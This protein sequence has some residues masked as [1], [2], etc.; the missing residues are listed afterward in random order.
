M[1]VLVFSHYFELAKELISAGSGV[2]EV[3]LLL[4]SDQADREGEVKGVKRVIICDV[5]SEDQQGLLSVIASLAEDYDLLILSSDKRGRE[6]IGQVAQKLERAVATEVS[7]L[8]LSDGKL[9]VERMTY[10]GKAI[11]VEELTLPAVI[12]VQKGKFKPLDTDSTHETL[13]CKS[14]TARSYEVLERRP[15][16]KLGIPL[17]KADV[18]VAAGRGFKRKEDLKLAYELA[19]L[20]NGVVGSTRPLAADLK[21]MPEESWIGI[22]GVRIAPKLLFVVGA[23]GQQQFS[24][25]IIDSKVI[26][27]V[28][29]DPSAPIFE[30]SDYCIVRDL[31]EFLPALIKKLRG[32]R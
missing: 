7:S 6:L 13:H 28:N 17:D 29:N 18:V 12:S 5:S 10:G 30:N 11:S 31:Y 3:S 1:K 15:K 25:G 2:G 23:S 9:I 20:F 27:A 16:P 8:S 4:T 14:E 19:E 22:S 24:A 32:L 21:W 26:V